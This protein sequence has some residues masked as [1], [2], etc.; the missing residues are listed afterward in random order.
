MSIAILVKFL[1][2]FS[3]DGRGPELPCQQ[4]IRRVELVVNVVINL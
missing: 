2:Y 1:W 3:T 4:E